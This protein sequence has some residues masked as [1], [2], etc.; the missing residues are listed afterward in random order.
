MR[1]I[2]ERCNL[3]IS[4]RNNK[5]NP[6]FKLLSI[7]CS[8]SAQ[9]LLS[10]LLDGLLEVD[11]PQV[12]VSTTRRVYGALLCRPVGFWTVC[13]RSIGWQFFLINSIVTDMLLYRLKALIEPACSFS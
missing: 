13:S 3:Q 1:E 12:L 2:F 6:P 11:L 9:L 8:G 7:S 5:K 10:M 4:L